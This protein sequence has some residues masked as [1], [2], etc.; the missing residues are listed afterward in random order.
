MHSSN[1]K[2]SFLSP[3]EEANFYVNHWCL[4]EKLHLSRN[5]KHYFENLVSVEEIDR[6]VC[7][8][9][10]PVTNFNLAKDNDPL[11]VESYCTG[12]LVDA[13]KV[14]F[15]HQNGATIILRSAEQWSAPI[16][17]LRA[18]AEKL[19]GYE[20]QI[21]V[22]IT[23]PSQKS[24]PP[25]W[26]THELIVMQLLGSK[27]WRLFESSE[28]LPLEGQRFEVGKH[29][30][31]EL[32]DNI[33][34]NAG[35]TLF[36]PRGTIH[37]PI[38]DTYSIHLSI[39]IRPLRLADLVAGILEQESNRVGS[40]LRENAEISLDDPEL[41]PKLQKTIQSVCDA[42]KL[43]DSFDTFS[44]QIEFKK[45]GDNSGRLLDLI[46]ETYDESQHL[47]GRAGITKRL[48]IM[49]NKVLLS[50][51]ISEISLPIRMRAAVEK[52][53]NGTPFLPREL[54]GNL[55]PEEIE[56]LCKGL[57]QQGILAKKS[58]CNNA[59]SKF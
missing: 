59:T 30:V 12:D 51:G 18:E 9:R 23:P 25:H 46:D 53:I 32:T 34:L 13:N 16:A 54:P 1:S 7:S 17:K 48:S 24:T 50:N 29:E 38:A 49:D 19:L 36:L 27:Q 6:L 4:H 21:N 8:T 11:P 31:G 5:D 14:L 45:W 56:A 33:R 58:N 41:A 10:I 42:A 28:T 52:A 44:D 39:G 26:D 20:A 37:E 15:H 22:Y 3:M 35:D 55:S 47:T 57:M 43:I 40:I 2:N